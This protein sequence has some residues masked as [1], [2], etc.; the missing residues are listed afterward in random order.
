MLVLLNCLVVLRHHAQVALTRDWFFLLKALVAS[1]SLLNV[2][3]IN[4]VV[5]LCLF[6]R[7]HGWPCAAAV[8]SYSLNA[9]HLAGDRGILVGIVGRNDSR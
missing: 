6:A 7:F 3:N 5:E 9:T 1:S 8:A 4:L 2:H